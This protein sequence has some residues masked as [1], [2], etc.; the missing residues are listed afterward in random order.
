LAFVRL[1]AD[2]VPDVSF[3]TAGRTDVFLLDAVQFGQGFTHLNIAPDEKILFSYP[4]GTGAAR[5]I[6]IY[7]LT[8]NGAQDTTWG[9]AGRINVAATN[10]EDNVRLTRFQSDGKL[11]I[12]SRTLQLNSVN[13]TYEIL[14][15]RLNADGTTDTTFGVN[16]VV[17]TVIGAADTS[18]NLAQDMQVLADGKIVVAGHR[19][20]TGMGRDVFLVRYLSNGTV[21]TSFG[22]SGVKDIPLTRQN[23]FVRSLSVESDGS[24]LVVG[25]TSLTDVDRGNLIGTGFVLKVKNTVGSALI[26]LTVNK[27]GSGSV[28]SDITGINCGSSCVASFTPNTMIT[29]TA[30]PAMGSTFV[31]WSGASCSGTGTCLITIAAA[32]TVTAT[33][34]GASVSLLSVQSR[35]TH[36]AAGTFNLD[37]DKN[38]AITGAVTVEPRA[39]GTGH[40]IVFKFSGPVTSTSVTSLD[41]AGVNPVGSATATIPQIPGDEVV[42]TLLGVPDNRRAK[43]T[44]SNVNAIGLNVSAS[45][46]FLLGD[47]N[48]T[49]SI[50]VGDTS[51]VK[52]RSG[53]ATTALNFLFDINTSG[54]VNASDISAVKARPA[55]TLAP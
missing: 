8:A 7:R 3:G 41:A 18:N 31:G 38:V 30:T 55:A 9:T 33:F 50:S 6:A 53:Q 29:L 49:R 34:G 16:G 39:I 21:D 51:G 14:M 46:G 37:I 27:I 5:D 32:T 35:K 48:N 28:A 17:E 45:V 47:G 15:T 44:L 1:T 36:G 12:L 23:D 20:G 26:N 19:N 24:L 11:L 2:G 22:N 54:V 4:Y 10:R 43:I 13:G 25:N 40:A 52:A 42:V